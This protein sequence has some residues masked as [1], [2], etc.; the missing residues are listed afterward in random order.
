MYR[1]WTVFC[2]GCKTK[3]VDYGK[4][5]S[6]TSSLVK[7]LPERILKSYFPPSAPMGTCPHCANVFARPMLYKGQPAWKLMTQ[8]IFVKK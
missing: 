6:G 8:K 1:N 7:L 2:N 5:G 3:L 4:R